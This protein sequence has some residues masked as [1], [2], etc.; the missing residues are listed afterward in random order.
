MNVITSNR[1]KKLSTNFRLMF[2]VQAFLSVRTLNVVAAIF[3]L[4]RGLSLSQVFYLSMF[5]AAINILSEV[6][7]S[8]LADRWGRKKTIVLSA[9][10]YCINCVLLIFSDSFT[11]FALSTFFFALSYACY[12]GTDEALVYD[13]SRELGED[14]KSLSRLGQY[15]AAEKVFKIITP[16]IGAFVARDLMEGQFTW[17]LI[18]DTAAAFS[19]LILSLFIVEPKQYFEVE[20][21]EA[22]IFY[23]ALKL[24]KNN[25]SLMLAICN[26]AFNFTGVFIIWR[27]HQE[28]FANIGTT[29]IALGIGWSVFNLIVT[30]L[31][32]QIYL[33]WPT[34]SSSVK[35][36]YLNFITIFFVG[37]FLVAINFEIHYYW[38][39]LIY[40]CL[41]I[42]ENA[43]WPIFSHMFNEHSNSFNRATTLSLSNF[44]KSVGD[45]PLLAIASLLVAYK[46]VY[47]IYFV[48]ILLI[49]TSII[50]QLPKKLIMK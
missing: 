33:L 44:V 39:L 46:L 40:F 14:G 19:A 22:G 23:D 25:P 6:P 18:I 11:M 9:V 4:S 41:N 13:T 31:N 49:L 38:V 48:L 47:P 26:R 50:F 29:I 45:I 37:L 36:N 17:L 8:Y 34:K 24:I 32:Y 30:I 3:Y 27:Y 1:R 5:W 21:V 2:L 35:I 7:S 43:R 28:L 15:S 16:L 10:L 42:A 12:S 20:R